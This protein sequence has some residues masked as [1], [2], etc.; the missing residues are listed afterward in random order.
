MRCMQEKV[1]IITDASKLIEQKLPLQ[2]INIIRIVISC[3]GTAQL[4]NIMYQEIFFL[5][6][7]L[8]KNFRSEAN[9]SES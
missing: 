9:R 1:I 6:K 7:K 3:L 4:K 5:P 2:Q 8:S